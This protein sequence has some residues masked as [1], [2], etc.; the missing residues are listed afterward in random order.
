[1][2]RWHDGTMRLAAALFC[3]AGTAAWGQTTPKFTVGPALQVNPPGDV[4]FECSIGVSQTNHLEAFVG[5]MSPTTPGIATAAIFALPGGPLVAHGNTSC[6][7]TDPWVAPEP[8]P[9]GRIWLT[10]LDGSG[11][12]GTPPTNCASGIYVGWKNAGQGSIPAAQLYPVPGLDGL[13]DKPA[14]AIGEETPGGPLN[15]FY[16]TSVAKRGLY[17]NRTVN[18]A[19]TSNNP[20]SGA[21]V[22]AVKEV[23]PVLNNDCDWKGWGAVGVV[24]DSG[25]IVAALTDGNPQNN[26]NRPYIYYSDDQGATWHSDDG[27]DPL[28]IDPDENIEATTIDVDDTGD[29][30]DSQSGDTPEHA[31]RRQG[32]PSIAIDRSQEP[33]HIYVAFYARSA[34]GAK[35]TDIYIARSTD[36][37]TT[38]PSDEIVQITDAMLGLTDPVDTDPITGADQY[39]PAIAVDSCGGVNLMFY[40]NRFDPDRDDKYSPMDVYFARVT[41][42][43]PPPVVPV[44]NTA[45]M[46][47][48]TF[49]ADH[50]TMPV[51]AS[52]LGDYQTMS[53]SADGKWIWAA[54]IARESDQ[55]LIWTERNCYVHRIQIHCLQEGDFNGDGGVNE[56]DVSEFLTALATEDPSADVDLDWYVTDADFDLFM[57]R[58]NRGRRGD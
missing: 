48:E 31:D 25:R 20:A 32:A 40:D 55:T 14:L 36:A 6:G 57:E 29:C 2:A 37:G 41:N 33:N 50:C 44:V 43:G 46:T 58:Y 5:S 15:R 3:V 51:M 34:P 16:I 23:K 47:S 18:L 38:W 8:G 22:W 13:F 35:N 49:P 17:C 10:A 53:V 54:Y 24:T 30:G 4:W 28:V 27:L 26:A 19:T 52:Y 45:R 9:S 56:A 39:T 11:V 7:T 1:M 21:P 42:F 12:V